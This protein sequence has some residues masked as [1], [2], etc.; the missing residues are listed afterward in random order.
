[1]QPIES[2]PLFTNLLDH[3]KAIQLCLSS[4]LQLPAL[5]LI[6]CG[7]DVMGNL[8]RPEHQMEKTRTDFIRY[9]ERYMSC[10][11]RLG[12]SGLDLY[13]AR[14]GVLHKYTMDSRLTAE[15][16]AR[17]IIYAW[18]DKSPEEANK[19]LRTLGRREVAVKIEELGESFVT[20]IEAFMAALKE[21]AHFT[22]IVQ[23]RSR[24]LFKDQQ[25]F[26][27]VD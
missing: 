18:G 6:Y 11:Q 12:V 14:C 23:Q 22:A 27:G 25:S 10:A 1:M 15:G 17:R 21:D 7:I 3:V 5:V 24:K 2:N 13:A 4:R 19:V 8:S 26:P 9:A 20:G 16:K